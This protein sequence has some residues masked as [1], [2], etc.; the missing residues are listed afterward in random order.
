MNRNQVIL[1][2]VVLAIVGSAGLILVKRHQESWDLPETKMGDKVLPHFQPNDVA[3]IHIKGT[4]DLNLVLMDNLWR[5]QERDGYPANFH[6]ISDVLIK[7]KDLKVVEGDGVAAAD[8]SHFNLAEP[9]QGPGS[10]TLVEFKDAQGRVLDSLLLGKKHLRQQ[11]DSRALVG[12]GEPDGCYILLPGDPKEVLLIS[13]P[14]S[15]LV[16]N[17]AAWLS[18]D[19]I[20]VDHVKSIAMTSPN[21]NDSWKISRDTEKSPWILAGARPGEILDETKASRAASALVSPRF[22]DVLLSNTP[23]ATGLDQPRLVTIATFDNLTY[24]LRVGA[25]T[26]AGNYCMTVAV[27]AENPGAADKTVTEKLRQEQALAQHV[28][29]VGSW[30]LDP[31]V[32]DRA[33]FMQGYRDENATAVAPAP[34]EKGATNSMNSG[35]TPRVI[36]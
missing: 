23:S 11:T 30:I 19:F 29:T 31:L 4:S 12:N 28:Y 8:L 9:G 26:S 21:T 22:A 1:I 18:R 14:L 7:L 27:A 13:D 6:Q 20:K 2:L 34:V 5:V 17:P 15:S 36:Q 33:Q 16:P 24:T 32:H 25:K 3:A 10:G 35:W